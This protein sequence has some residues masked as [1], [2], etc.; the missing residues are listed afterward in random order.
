MKHPLSLRLIAIIFGC[1]FVLFVVFFG[2]RVEKDMQEAVEQ[3]ARV[4]SSSL[5]NLNQNSQSEY[6]TIVAKHYNYE[7]ISILDH[8]GEIFLTASAPT[9][10]W[11]K[12]ILLALKLIPRIKI[13]VPII[14]DGEKIGSVL[15]IWHRDTIYTYSYILFVLF[16]VLNI[17]YFFKR[18]LKYHLL[19][20][21][22]VEERTKH[23][24]AEIT[25]RKQAE[26][27]LH[28]N[29]IIFQSFLENSPVYIF[30]KDHE[31]RSVMLSRNYE[32]LLGMPLENIIGNTMDDLFP[33]DLTKS[34]I[35]DDKR[36]LREGEN[37]TVVEKFGGKTYETT[38]FP[39][40]I[41]NKPNMLAGFTLDITD[42]K[43]AEEEKKKLEALL[44]QAQ[45]MEAIGT[46]AGG[47]AHDFN[48]IL[49][50]IMGYSELLK[51]SVSE[52]SQVSSYL[53]NIMTAGN[54]AKDLVQQ[55]LAFSRQSDRELKPV[56]VKIIV[57]EALKLLRA[58][59]P[60]TIEIRQNINSDSLVM[61]DPTQVHQIIMNLCTNAAHAMQEHGGIL[62]V[63]LSNAGHNPELTVRH[64]DLNP[65]PYLVL[66]VG[67]TGH[68]M[69]ADVLERIF[70]PFY[71][72]K[73]KG[74]GTGMGLS[75]VHGIVKSYG[76][77]I[78]ADSKIGKGSIFYV[79]LPSIES[80]LEQDRDTKKGL[81][82]GTEHI[83]YVD[84][85]PP[86]LE[87][88]EKMLGSLGYQVDT[89]ISSL[90]ALNLFRAQP[91]RFDLV[92][93]D[94]TMPQMTGDKLAE[95][96]IAIREDIPIILC[97]GF[98][99]RIREDKINTIGIKGL[100]LKP[101]VRNDLAQMVRKVLDEAKS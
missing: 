12:T 22:K 57:K 91:D 27:A 31:I 66:T 65:G 42:R 90:E 99:N 82:K 1:L 75:V 41:S 55:I 26:D 36:I 4:V 46:L 64:P 94:M 14:Y 100:L 24:T 85:E 43:K 16:L 38:K 39:I 6:L 83:L 35:E 33:S 92:I 86:L 63:D 84:D 77:K 21:N 18:L 37:I 29:Q 40:F 44:G 51:M 20:E 9:P 72:T 69:Q 54:R 47:I 15:A 17:I 89:R 32:Q 45:K 67:D 74:E 96:L 49:S 48:N 59:L 61:S 30:F 60:S 73:K 28:E 95:E 62:E 23:L 76:G 2:N 58:S 11:H 34:M 56:S 19:L 50:G 97:T 8:D 7:T 13:T 80:N 101:I 68:G 10:N 88:G 98:S 3:H 70:D 71:T 87:I 79:F 78:Y 53:D 5:W 93:T 25:E 81:L 52:D